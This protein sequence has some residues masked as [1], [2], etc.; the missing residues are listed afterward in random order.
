VL[1][2]GAVCCATALFVRATD[3]AE[4]GIARHTALANSILLHYS[5]YESESLS[6]VLLES[7]LT[8]Y[9]AACTRSS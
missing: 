9:D 5:R 4:S 7:W 8:G 6:L 2:D 1:F 3:D